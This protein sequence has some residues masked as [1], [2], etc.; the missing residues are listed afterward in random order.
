MMSAIGGNVILLCLYV[1]LIARLK[2][3]CGLISPLYILGEFIPER[4]TSKK[5]KAVL[6]SCN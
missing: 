4:N 2:S 3:N 5:K 1:S 6:Y